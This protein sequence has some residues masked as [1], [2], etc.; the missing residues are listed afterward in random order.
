[1][2]TFNIALF[3]F[4][5]CFSIRIATLNQMGRTWDEPLYVDWGYK[6]IELIKHGNFSDIFWYERPGFPPLSKYI[7]GLA[8][9]WDI[10]EFN[11]NYYPVFNYDLTFVRLTSA[12]FSS[13]T[14]VMIFIFGV[15][16]FSLKT[17]V[18]SSII[19][20]LLPL[21]IGYGQLAT[22]ESLIL[23]FFTV[24]VLSYIEFLKLNKKVYLILTGVFLGLSFG[25]K[26]TNFLLVPLIIWIFFVWSSINI[27]HFREYLKYAKLLIVIFILGFIVFFLTWPMP[28]FHLS[29]VVNYNINLRY[30]PYSVP[31]FFFGKL[32][33]VP[34]VY[35]IIYFVITTPFLWL[36]LFVIGL[37]ARHKFSIKLG[38]ITINKIKRF[39]FIS[40][41][42][43][44]DW[45]F[46][47]TV[48]WFILPF[49]QSL[50]NFK[51]HGIRYIIEI[52]APFS[53]IAGIG[54]SFILEK[55]TR[56]LMQ[57]TF[58]LLL[59][60]LYSLFILLIFKPYYL[61]Y[62]NELTGGTGN[63][64]KSRLFQIGWWGQ[65][66][67][68]AAQFVIKNADEKSRVGIAI[69]PVDVLPKMDGLIVEKYDENNAYDYIIVNDY[70]VL[71][72]GFDDSKIKKLYD[73][74]YEVKV[75]D[76]VLVTV[77]KRR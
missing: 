9:Y 39:F 28:W 34:K 14:S 42:F 17:G 13:L 59:L 36:L 55:Y 30:S 27:K 12:L 57:K 1:M 18:F 4:L 32:I 10:K 5:A 56:N 71:R 37:R 73:H 15:R 11:Q 40:Q 7:Y 47:S 26:Y 58:L 6:T 74:I 51:Q 50:Y 63:V 38:K 25:V 3:I 76:A 33:L 43:R 23:F 69:S 41:D 68:E 64:Y 77:Y 49:F 22:L 66:V 45:L 67:G 61:D 52:Y 65:G 75:D 16:N 29:H 72:E 19:F 35:Y 54:L 53:L 44:K 48:I 21:S 70:K 24:T 60:T 20:S 2:K 8:S 46:Y 62:F 31:E